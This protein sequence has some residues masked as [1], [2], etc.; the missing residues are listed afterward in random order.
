MAIIYRATVTP[1]KAELS[2]SW[3]DRQSWGGDGA[4]EVVGSYRFDDPDGE[5]GVEALLVRRGSSL[6]HVPLTYR[7]A[8]LDGGEGHLVGTMDHS[9]LGQRW[10]YEAMNDPVAVACFDRALSGE[11]E[12]ATMELYDGDQLVERREPSVRIERRTDAAAPVGDLRLA[13]ALDEDLHGAEALVATWDGGA[14][15]VAAR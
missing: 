12:Q 7:G 11:Q 9:V 14:A 3:L 8:P 13:T 4:V 1:S 2:E 6:L 10:I 5:V 15:V